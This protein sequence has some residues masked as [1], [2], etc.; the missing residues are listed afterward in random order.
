MTLPNCAPD[1]VHNYHLHIYMKLV[2]GMLLCRTKKIDGERCNSWKMRD[3]STF[4]GGK[5]RR[6]RVTP[7]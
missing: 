6:A 2:L 4:M 5:V 1:F 7:S 3:K